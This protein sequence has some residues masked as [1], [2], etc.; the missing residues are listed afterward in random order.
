[1]ARK[2]R[3]RWT[4]GFPWVTPR[5][6][7]ALCVIAVVAAAAE[8]VHALAFVAAALGFVLV[9]FAAADASIGPARRDVTV[10]RLPID[11]LALR[12]AAV[13]RYAVANR[14]ATP[15][16]FEIVDTPIEILDLPED[17]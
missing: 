2:A 4:A 7:T 11:H 5:F 1:M 9:G 6:V 12:N 14:S 10:Q 13:L 15:F 16:A 17:A 8:F 3:R